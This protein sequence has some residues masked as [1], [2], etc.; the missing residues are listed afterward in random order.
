MFFERGL[1]LSG[2]FN[3]TINA[4]ISP[5]RFEIRRPLLTLFDIKWHP[6]MPAENFSFCPAVLRLSGGSPVPALV[7]YPRPETKAAYVAMPPDNLIEILAPPLDGV[8]TG[9]TGTLA[10]D[11]GQIVIR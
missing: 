5:R 9:M 6:D 4:D 2:Y 10:I 3:G 8:R 11:P 7:Y 1:D